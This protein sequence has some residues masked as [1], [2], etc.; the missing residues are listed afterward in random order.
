MEME[1][2]KLDMHII[3]QA[4]AAADHAIFNL[5]SVPIAAVP[6]PHVAPPILRPKEKRTHPSHDGGV[7]LKT[8]IF[9]CFNST[10]SLQ[11][12]F[13]SCCCVLRKAFSSTTYNSSYLKDVAREESKPFV[14]RGGDDG[15]LAF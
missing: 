6:L 14:I 10:A 13:F 3:A 4:A 2:F 7:D 15:L 5:N 11:M 1:E 8:P 12:Y 9:S